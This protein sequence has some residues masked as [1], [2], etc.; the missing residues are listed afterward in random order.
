[1]N[2][3]DNSE[4]KE[5][6]FR[7]NNPY[8]PD[9]VITQNGVISNKLQYDYS[10]SEWIAVDSEFLGLN[11]YRDAL[12]SIQIASPDKDN[13][14]KQRLEIVQLFSIKDKQEV[15]S[16]KADLIKL[17]TGNST[18]IFHVFSADI[19]MLNRYLKTKVTGPIF[20]TKVA[21]KIVWT[22]A[23]STG[24]SEF[25]KTFIDPDFEPIHLANAR[26]E[27][28]VNKWSEKM[29]KYASLDVLYLQPMQAKLL[30]MAKDRN[31]FDVV[32]EAMSSIPGIS[33]VISDGFDLDI[34][35]F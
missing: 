24:K 10:D 26:W 28:P 11:L 12:C 1:M 17:F 2:N 19:T 29:L 7:L 14:E 13:K 9:E 16:V 15:E 25:V 31:R 30:Q 33:S 3:I 20:D 22:N 6:S 18:K 4:K 35:Q 5:F 32:N 21:T 34:F 23:R 27:L 8:K